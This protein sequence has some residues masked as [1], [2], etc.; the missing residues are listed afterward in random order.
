MAEHS[1]TI[2]ELWLSHYRAH[3]NRNDDCMIDELPLKPVLTH[4]VKEGVALDRDKAKVVIESEIGQL[5]E[6]DKISFG[7]F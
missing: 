6:V 3:Y 5:D 4:L 2:K 1:V 7:E